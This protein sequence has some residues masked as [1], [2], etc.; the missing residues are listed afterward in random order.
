[1]G[2]RWAFDRYDGR[3]EFWREGRAIL[4]DSVRLT[5]DDGPLAERMGRFNV[6]ATVVLTGPLVA[7]AAAKLISEIANLPVPPR[8]DLILSAAPL[9]EDGALL[10][11]AGISTEQTSVVIR[12]YLSF[13]SPHLGGELWSRKW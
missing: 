8:S 1:M 4:Y 7:E 12:Q 3:L 5:Q 10:R 6:W 9:G 11:M 13:L 2:E